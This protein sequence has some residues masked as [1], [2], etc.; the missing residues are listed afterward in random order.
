MAT[1]RR[2][3]LRAVLGSFVLA[4]AVVGG[5][6]V[7]VPAL[8][9]DPEAA[10]AARY[11]AIEVLDR[12]GERLGTLTAAHHQR[13]LARPLAAFSP[14]LIAATVEAE[15]QRFWQHRGVDPV[16]VGRA[17]L[18]NLRSRRVVS[19]ASTLT[20][21]L[22]K[23]IAPGPRGWRAKWRETAWAL[24]LEARY[25]KD[26]ILALY[27]SHAPYGGLLRG[28]E[29]ASRALFARS[30]DALTWRQAALLAVLPRAPSVLDL[31]RDPSR[32]VRLADRLLDRLQARG[33]LSAEE[34]RAAAE[35]AVEVRASPSPLEAPHALDMLRQQEADG[36]VA[37]IR[38][39]LDRRLQADLQA[40]VAVETARL[41]GRGADNASVVVIEAGS[42]AIRA[43]IGSQAYG[44]AAALGANNGA[45]AR[46]SPGSTLKPFIY[47]LGMD[48]GID[49]A[50]VWLDTEAHFETPHGDWR[51]DNYARRY[52]GPVRTRLA[53]SNSLNVPA[54][55]ALS[56]IG[57][58][59]LQDALRRAG[60]GGLHRSAEHHGLGLALGDADVALLDLAGAYS[61]FANAGVAVVPSL[62]DGLVD[63]DGV[64]HGLGTTQAQRLFSPRAAS[65]VV[66]M[67]AD[68]LA[69][70][71]AF[72]H[73]G[74]LDLGHAVAVKT[75][76][77]KGNRD[78][79]A[80]AVSARYVVAVWVG[81]FDGRATEGWTG[82]SAAGPLLR[83]VL[84]RLSEEGP[85]RLPSRADGLQ[86]VTICPASG[87]RPGPLCPHRAQEWVFAEAATR[88]PCTKHDHGG[89]ALRGEAR[90][91]A[92]RAGIALAA[93][94]WVDAGP[95]DARI[96]LLSPAQ[97]ARFW[98][99]SQ[100]PG[101]DQAIRIRA[102]SEPAGLPVEIRVDGR[103]LE[104][105][106]V[107]D[108]D[109]LWSPAP[110][111]HRIEVRLVGA[112][113]AAGPKARSDAVTVD[114]L[115]MRRLGA[116][117]LP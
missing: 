76:T 95:A 50:E 41:R 19:G 4:T 98:L 39:S 38:T 84:D 112:G 62:V 110:G 44:D 109:V 42:G 11:Q 33:V 79:L 59:A 34:R 40:I 102:A 63:G 17:A 2:L 56:R 94:P 66:D 47:A 73:G 68:P 77:S 9:P 80:V 14:R 92:E 7:A 101:A 111:H 75:G 25:D 106:S 51:P 6:F 53:L 18:G 60:V 91:W 16:A 57:V 24:Q 78:A 107:A 46:R 52:H 8:P 97:G 103:L 36:V 54:V 23:M 96:R 5:L 93:E 28:A 37:A 83:G 49:A 30:A 86:R 13:G 89:S 61:A 48:Q 105:A 115:G 20:Q 71:P 27:L 45:L 108:R 85:L 31:R 114:V 58:G 99:D 1:W 65:V 87:G 70:S 104:E 29:S 10:L 12:N 113:A 22:A 74:G 26:A 3:L 15:D 21:Q 117:S 90:A 32:A 82:A 55:R 72:G 81:N 43:M 64:E 88:G 69:R 116:A 67:L 35:E 100:R